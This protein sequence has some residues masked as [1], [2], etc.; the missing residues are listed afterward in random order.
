MSA[1]AAGGTTWCLDND[2]WSQ[3]GQRFALKLLDGHAVPAE[4]TDLD[5]LAGA[6]CVAGSAAFL[7][8]Q[9]R[10]SP[11]DGRPLADPT[12]LNWLP[13][14]ASSQGNRLCDGEAGGALAALLPQLTA[15]WRQAGQTMQTAA[16]RIDAPAS[17]GLLFFASTAGGHRDA[18]FALGRSGA[19]WLWQ[20][21]SSAWVPLRA[22]RQHLGRHA[23]E[24]WAAAVV[25]LPGARGDDLVIA[26]DEGADL[27]QI[28]PVR[29]QYLL[30]RAPG[31]ALGAP[32]RLGE[33][34]LVPQRAGH[35]AQMALRRDGRWHGVPISGDLPTAMPVLGTPI[36][37][38]DG[39]GL[40]WIGESGWL[41][42]REDGTGFTARWE[43]WP[44]GMIAR[45]RLGPP[46]RNGEGDWQLLQNVADK[47]TCAFLLGATLRTEQA[48]KRLSVST[49]A[50][51]FQLNV[52]VARPWDDYDPDDHPDG[53]EHVVHPFLEL[54]RPGQ[55][56]NTL[57]YLRAANPT[58][59]P[60]LAFY[61]GRQCHLAQYA[62]GWPLSPGQVYATESTEPWNAQWFIHDGALWLW[63]DDRGMLLRWSRE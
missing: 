25:S 32:G 48:L 5:Y 28:D 34:A 45:P 11:F 4:V 7:P 24:S 10:H 40:A 36:T 27:L 12:A 53:L 15:H 30:D 46:F 44:E 2:A 18:L 13:P 29:L 47:S 9:F 43:A 31:A 61:E 26:S 8:R 50:S 33:A 51:T 16:T 22:R 23:F 63:I 21:G 14:A 56:G 52:R 55:P 58:R 19:L 49:G 37:T 59:A 1:G 20:R 35:G 41:L 6:R 17:N 62:I 57:L 54:Q 60:L 38:A 42:V 3:D 39:H